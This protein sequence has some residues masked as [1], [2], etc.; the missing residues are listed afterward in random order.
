MTRRPLIAAGL[1]IG[2]GMGGFVDG[3]LFHQ[4]LQIHN[5]VSARR[6]PETLV[7]VEINMVWDGLF[8]AFTWLVT[9]LGI[10]MLWRALRRADVPR[11]GRTLFGSMLKGWGAFNLVEGIINH[12]IL[13]VHHVVERLGVSVWDW[14]FLGSGVVLLL[15]GY[16]LIR[17]DGRRVDRPGAQAGGPTHAPRVPAAPRDA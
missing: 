5:M 16:A 11:L 1:M 8:H 7:N 13:H 3:I 6:P 15:L 9:A 2:I 10:W 17:A 12:H 4:I 14:V